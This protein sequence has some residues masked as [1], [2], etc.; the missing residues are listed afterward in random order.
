MLGMFFFLALYMQNI[1]GYSPLE[2]GVRFLP[3]TLVIM[4]VAPISGRL[5]DRIGPRWPI[6][7]GLSLVTASLFQFTRI[8]ASTTY[9][10]PAARLRADGRRDRADDVADVDRGDERG[11]RAKAGIASGVLSMFRMVGGTFGVAAIGALFQGQARSNLDQLL[12]GTVS[13]GA[14]EDLAHQLG[15]GGLQPPP[16]TSPA[17]AHRIAVAGKTA[18]IDAL[19]TSM[20]LSAAVAFAGVVVG[21]TMINARGAPARRARGR[22]GRDRRRHTGRRRDSRGAPRDLARS[23]GGD[24]GRRRRRPGL[25]PREVDLRQQLDRRPRRGAAIVSRFELSIGPGS[26]GQGVSTTQAT[27]RPTARAA[28]SVS[29]V[30]LIVPRPGG[31]ATTSG[32]PSSSGEVADQVAGGQRHQQPADPLADER[33]RRSA[34]AARAPL[35]QPCR[36]DRLAGQLRR[37]VR[38]RPAGRSGRGRSR[39]RSAPSRPPGAAAR[40][41]ARPPSS[42]P[43]T[44][45]LKTATRSPA[46][47]QRVR[48]HRRDHG[49]ADLGAGAGD[50]DAAQRG[51]RGLGHR[52]RLDRPVRSG[53]RARGRHPARA[54][55]RRSA[56]PPAAARSARW[57]AIT[58]KP[59]ARGA[60]RARSAGGSPGRRRRARAPARR[61]PS[62]APASPTID[63]HD[64]GLGGAELRAPRPPAPRA[65]PPR[66]RCSRSTRSV[67]G[68]AAPARRRR[69]DDRRRR[70]G[71]EDE[72]AGGV[73]QVLDDLVAGADVGAVAAERLAERADD[74]VDL[75]RDSP[76]AATEPAAAGPERAG[77]VG[78]VDHQPAVVAA[79]QLAPA[80]PAARRRRPSRRRRR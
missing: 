67:L 39:R 9:S 8:D 37:E 68:R 79:R 73:D 26:S 49:L 11:R 60:A 34:A 54:P 63:R 66:S 69:G 20:R 51:S 78:L 33:R 15:S 13:S 44:R 36:V 28:S 2:A 52:H 56:G 21:V 64:L 12:S 10:R 53:A 75:A 61:A 27:S 57:V 48:D 6:T 43:V 40:G 71:R 74:H 58:V 23:D 45:G 31:A 38:A 76:A 5:A 4:V 17:E 80:P 1:L 3:T 77:R 16:G 30:W 29:S 62:S 46:G 55:P 41:R 35:E 25:R 32:S 47:G 7:V 18:F 65:G 70:R 72:R 14:R 22:G 50:E 59:Q 42:R 19:A 24:R